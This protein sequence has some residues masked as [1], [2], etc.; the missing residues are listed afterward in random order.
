MLGGILL[1]DSYRDS[2]RDALKDS[3]RDST[4]IIIQKHPEV[5]IESSIHHI[6]LHWVSQSRDATKDASEIPTKK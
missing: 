1:K 4:H 6:T 2:L 5:E 3:A